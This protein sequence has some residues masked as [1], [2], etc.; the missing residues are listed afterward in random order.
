MSLARLVPAIVAA[1][2]LLA[3]QNLEARIVTL[4]G[5]NL[6]TDCSAH[7]TAAPA[8]QW[9]LAGTCMGYV[10]AVMDALSSGDSVNGFQACVPLNA[11]MKQVVDVVS[12]FIVEHP[13]RADRGHSD[14]HNG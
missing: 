14:F 2:V 7:N 6:Y 10:I 4:S 5:N 1:N 9:L 12:A 8:D 11:D 13:T 3:P